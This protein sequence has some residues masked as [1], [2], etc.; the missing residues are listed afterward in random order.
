MNA[1]AAAKAGNGVCQL[2]A[3]LVAQG[4][5]DTVTQPL[6]GIRPRQRPGPSDGFELQKPE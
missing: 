1:V 2:P 4:W 3:E 5:V 6:A